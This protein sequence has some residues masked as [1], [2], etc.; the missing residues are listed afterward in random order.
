M[1]VKPGF[2][3][4][5]GFENGAPTGFC[6]DVFEAVVKE[7]SYDVPRHY[8]QFGDGEGSSNGT[9]D[10]LVYEVYLKVCMV[11]FLFHSASL[12]IGL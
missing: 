5:V 8:E 10:E 7:L 2:E 9:Y 3:E 11:F 1:P 12:I 4:F 6:V